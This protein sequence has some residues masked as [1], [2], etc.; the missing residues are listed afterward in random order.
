[1]TRA[2]SSP[3]TAYVAE[4]LRLYCLLPDTPDRPRPLDRRLAAEL[5]RRRVPL[6][7]IRAAFILA[8]AR[9]TFSPSAPLPAIR[10]LHYFLPI[11]EEVQQEPLEPGYLEHLRQLLSAA[12]NSAAFQQRRQTAI[13]TE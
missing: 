11:L 9:R 2:P 12:S 6:D 3:R 7:L 8:T 4:V 1:V 5:E 10:S 13:F